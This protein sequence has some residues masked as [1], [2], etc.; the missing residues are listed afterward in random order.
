MKIQSEYFSF[1]NHSTISSSHDYQ[2]HQ[3]CPQRRCCCFQIALQWL[4]VLPGLLLALPDMSVALPAMSSVLPDLSL[5]F[6]GAPRFVVSA[7]RCSPGC[8]QTS[9]IH[10]GFS[11]VL[12]GVS[13][14]HS[15]SPVHSGIW[16]P[17]DSGPT[18]SRHPQR[19]PEREIHFADVTIPRYLQNGMESTWRCN[20]K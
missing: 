14:G 10:L 15:I 16:P 5:V 3:R 11:L 4:E 7:P 18:T 8:Q 17:W 19:L 6:T 1:K 20:R 2:V 12:P 13:E 9:Y